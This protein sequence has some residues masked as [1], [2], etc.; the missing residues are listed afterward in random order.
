MGKIIQ[1]P[2]NFNNWVNNINEIINDNQ[3]KTNA[4]RCSVIMKSKDSQEAAKITGDS[5]ERFIS[6]GFNASHLQPVELSVPWYEYYLLD[7]AL[8][9]II[10][11]GVIYNLVHKYLRKCE[12]RASFRYFQWRKKV[13]ISSGKSNDVKFACGDE[14]PVKIRKKSHI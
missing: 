9:T 10:T 13:V 8:A 11:F 4:M 1:D 7:V 5:I 14:N 3:Y 2:A 6:W 12:T